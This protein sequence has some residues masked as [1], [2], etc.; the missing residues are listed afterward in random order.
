[1]N[2]STRLM[3]Q[4]GCNYPEAKNCTRCN[5]TG[6]APCSSCKGNPTSLG[7]SCCLNS[8]EELCE[9]Q[10]DKPCFH[11]GDAHCNCWKLVKAGKLGICD[12][13][14]T[15]WYTSD[16]IKCE[17]W[18]EEAAELAAE[19]TEMDGD[20]MLTERDTED[21]FSATSRYRDWR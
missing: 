2:Q 7:C 12:N 9:C 20:N 18:A 10:Y 3:R 6:E 13:C 11:C 8:G 16:G 5:D 21:D 17:C 19:L 14:G 4:H 15:E 1:M